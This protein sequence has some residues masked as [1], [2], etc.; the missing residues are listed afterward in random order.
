MTAARLIALALLV[1]PVAAARALPTDSEQPISVEADN[2]EIRDADNVS[3]YDGNVK[4]LQG[5]LEISSD[6]L[7]IHFNAANELLSMEMTGSPVHYRQ[8]DDQQRE[9]LGEAR[10]MKYLK[11]ESVLEM[12]ESAWF[13]HAGD[14]I[15]S[16]LIRIN[17]RDNSL[18]AGSAESDKRVKM[19][20]QPRQD[21][22]PPE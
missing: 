15:E 8:L 14:R 13:S 3:I 17:T 2:L 19:L 5:S 9:M 10:R 4:L 18:Q 7:V 11:S 6:R 20:I 1:L 21:T 12:R 16:D 22:A